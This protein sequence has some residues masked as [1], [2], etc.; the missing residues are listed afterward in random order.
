MNF[1]YK[2]FTLIFITFIGVSCEKK[3]TKSISTIRSDIQPFEKL[4]SS[5]TGIT[6]INEVEDQENFNILTYRNYYNGGGVG[7]GDVNNDGLLDIFFT[8]N[9]KKNKL[10]LNKGNFVFEDITEKAGVAG[11]GA[12]STGVAM[13]DVNADGFIDIYVCNSG[14]VDGS[15]RANELFINNGDGTFT[16]RAAEFGLDDEG[17]STHAV[18]I[19]LDGDGDLDCYLLNNSYKDPARI[20]FYEKERFIYGSSGGDRIYL[21]EDGTFVDRTQE[22]GIYS[23]DIGFGLGVSIGDLDNDLKPDM[24]ISN[25]F[26][27]RDYLYFNQGK[28]KFKE[29]LIDQVPYV[30]VASMGS[31]M[32][33]LNNDGWLDIFSTDML[34]HSNYRLKTSLKFDEYF[35]GDIKWKTSYYHQYVQNCLHIN[36]QDRTFKELAN[37]AGVAATDWSWGALI[38]DINLD[39]LKDIYVS[40]GV[41]H[42]ITDSDF[43]DFIGDQDAIK[44][45]VTENQRYDFR[46]FKKYLPHN[47][48]KNFA[49]INSGDLKFENLSDVLNISEEG[50]SNGAAYADLDN[51]GDFDLI[52]NNVNMEASLLKN[53]AVESGKKYIKIKLSGPEYNKFGIGTVAKM[54]QDGRT[55]VYHSMQSRGFQSSV[56]ADILFG[57]SEFDKERDSIVIIWPDKK[58]QILKGDLI[59][60]TIEVKYSDSE[61]VFKENTVFEVKPKIED[62]TAKTL[63]TDIVHI[64]NPYIDY[65]AERLMPRVHSTEGPKLVVGDVNGDGMD[66]VILLGAA[67]HSDQLL[68]FKNG[69]YI[70]SLQSAFD[71]DKA[72]E[73]TCGVLFDWD[74]DGDLDLLIGA[75]GNEYIN[76]FNFF[77]SR[78]YENDGK[79]NF[80]RI[81]D[82]FSQLVGQVS[83]IELGDFDGDGSVDVF[84]GGRSIPGNYGLTP[85]SF[86]Y[87]NLGGGR[88][89]DVTDAQTG[90]MGMVTD[91]KWLDIDK[92][93]KSELIVVGEWMTINVYKF[94]PTG[95]Q[96][97]Y[98]VPNSSGWWTS[99]Q[100]ADID[101]DGD[102]DFIAGNWGLNSKFAASP[103]RPITMYTHDF[104]ENKKVEPL[105]EWFYQKDEKAYPFATKADLTSQLPFLKKKVLKYK[106]FANSQI[107]DLIE[108]SVL[109]VAD[110]KS[111]VTLQ[112]VFLINDNGVLT[113]NP[114]PNEC[115]HTPIFASVLTDIDGDGCNDIFFGGNFYRLKPEVGRQ[116]G[117]RGGY[118]KG[119]CKGNFQYILPKESGISLIGEVRDAK[120]INNN[121]WI[122]R[123]NDSVKIYKLNQ[124]KQEL[125]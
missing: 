121:L 10:Y 13:R 95:F 97:L 38:F 30:S 26:W 53:N 124:Y 104:D 54:Y 75:G 96:I 42:D 98:T 109:S 70:E 45:V 102:M 116:D 52:I 101:D 4:I 14:D 113:L 77:K 41:Y 49:F 79:G 8:A 50:Y 110:K 85:R 1:I 80:T 114:L 37:Y 59:N 99:L 61:I 64:E 17:F 81:A 22:S 112:S 32:A 88:F 84:V 28:G 23:S 119:D 48:Q 118:L 120:I 40:N 6:F 108:P 20:S 57:I 63:S 21:N 46:D 24:F 16:E 76:G 25:D 100:I 90:P 60:S 56:D 19:D 15:N 51:D 58:C 69:K 111:V 107:K 2:I 83:C 105:I 74:E 91:A 82:K 12:W 93:G 117:N 47:P 106:D 89:E 27:E 94:G 55:Q 43:V 115:Q 68:L 65:N 44:Q 39:G 72:F 9:M 5:K 11:K 35:L 87:K 36:Q 29:S 92:D 71:A 62:I 73:G 66:D 122:A 123:N 78:Y 33:D 31:D 125:N 67:G 7:V 34:P 103:Q 86:I 18:F 3:I